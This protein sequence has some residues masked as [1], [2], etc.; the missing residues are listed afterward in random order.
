[1]LDAEFNYAHALSHTLS[2]TH[3][4]THPH[5]LSFTLSGERWYDVGRGVQLLLVL[6]TSPKRNPLQ[7]TNQP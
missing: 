4:L 5:T 6:F 7:P 1:M 2:L 3:T